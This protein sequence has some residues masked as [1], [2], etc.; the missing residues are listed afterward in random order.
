MA[1]ETLDVNSNKLTGEHIFAQIDRLVFEGWLDVQSTMLQV[2]SQ[3]SW[4]AAVPCVAF[5]CGATS[6]PVRLFCAHLAKFGR[7]CQRHKKTLLCRQHSDGIRPMHGTQ[8]SRAELQQSDRWA[9]FGADLFI[10]T[11]STSNPEK[12]SIINITGPIPTELG[13]CI[14][15]NCLGIADNQL[16]GMSIG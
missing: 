3:P 7:V 13:R 9:I 11:P 4:D 16:S 10:A 5:S 6:W 14:A 1:L 12:R 8:E 2:E 15:L